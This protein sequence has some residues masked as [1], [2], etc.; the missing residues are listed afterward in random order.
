M[1]RLHHSLLSL[2]LF[3]LL[4]AC[5]GTNDN[6]CDE[7]APCSSPENSYCDIVQ[8]ECIAPPSEDSCNRVQPCGSENPHCT[9]EEDG[10]CVQCLSTTHCADGAVCDTTS[11]L[12]VDCLENADCS[13]EGTV[14]D[15]ATS[16][17]VDCL[18]HED[19]SGGT[20]CDIE[21]QE[22]IACSEDEV[23]DSLCMDA[24]PDTPYCSALAGCVE[25]IDNTQCPAV[26]PVCDSEQ[27]TC[28]TCELDT[29]CDSGVCDRTSGT[30]LSEEQIVYV[31]ASSGTG[32]TCGTKSSPCRTII[33]GIGNIS[34]SRFTMLIEAGSYPE[35][36]RFSET[37][38]DLVSHGS[39]VLNPTLNVAG[40]EILDILNGA[41]VSLRGITIA[42]SS[43]ASG[44]N[45]I[46]CDNSSLSL[47]TVDIHSARKFGL[48][49]NQ[50]EVRIT[51]STITDNTAAGAGAGVGILGGSLLLVRSKIADNRNGGLTIRSASYSVQNSLFIDNGASDG[52]T[53]GVL[54]ENTAGLAE[55]F[56]FNT[57]FGNE[58]RNTSGR[59]SG[60]HCPN[61][62]LQA[63]SNIIL[64]G[65]GTSS[66]VVVDTSCSHTYSLLEVASAGIGN[67]S[68]LPG[69]V[70][71]VTFE[72]RSNSQCVDTADP[73]ATLN[74][75]FGGGSRPVGGRHDIGSD[76]AN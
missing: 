36:L 50:C 52:D 5:S 33:T 4:F 24:F 55:L 17:C 68:G 56:N 67:R 59:S 2:S 16:L 61:S 39:T 35:R 11:N 32:G 6:Y 34:E 28:T 31:D 18:A 64:E 40:Q 76:E 10:T 62:S 73:N 9:D 14:C 57:I 21:S 30:C 43:S 46:T 19:C 15:V 7:D 3:S 26:T 23:G 45:A 20:L 65:A 25:C 71:E 49:A 42:P 70:N 60:L 72:L 48:S 58:V 75:D 74:I 51:T 12:C 37:N 53:G 54:I 47:E 38:I 66:A 29:E 27:F 22:C 41:N 1:Q 44:N 63:S 8:K 69:F 13:A